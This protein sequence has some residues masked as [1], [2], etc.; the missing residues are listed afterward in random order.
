PAPVRLPPKARLK[1][2]IAYLGRI[3]FWRSLY[4]RGNFHHFDRRKS[5]S[6]ESRL[7][8]RTLLGVDGRRGVLRAGRVD[9]LGH[10][11]ET[12]CGQPPPRRYP[13]E[14]ALADYAWHPEGF[15]VSEWPGLAK[16]VALAMA[17][18]VFLS[19]FNWWA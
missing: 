10:D 7:G 9:G 5:F 2:G 18:T 13:D 6:S 19:M 16:A 11:L 4:G 1:T 3:R 14:P 17:L 8:P 15:E 12:I